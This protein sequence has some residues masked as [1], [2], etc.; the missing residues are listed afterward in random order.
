M[1]NWERERE[2]AASSSLTQKCLVT[3]RFES[4]FKT[5]ENGDERWHSNCN[6]YPRGE[7]ITHPRVKSTKKKSS[8]KIKSSPGSFEEKLVSKGPQSLH[9]SHQ[10]PI[11]DVNR[12]PSV[13]RTFLHSSKTSTKSLHNPFK[14]PLIEE[15][16]N[17]LDFYS[18]RNHTLLN[19]YGGNDLQHTS[20][21]LLNLPRLESIS[22]KKEKLQ[23]I[24]T[25]RISLLEPIA[26]FAS[27]VFSQS[28]WIEKS[29]L[30]QFC[31]VQAPVHWSENVYFI[32]EFG[33]PGF[34]YH[35]HSSTGVT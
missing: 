3:S 34:R 26:S 23:Q 27:L 7:N 30:V 2:I 5:T 29:H 6:H 19:G 15:I 9:D 32:L 11:V 28:H 20:C 12:N 33:I 21:H 31:A 22:F 10:S 35:L 13:F 18:S 17:Y 14:W 25:A 8:S 16:V 1:A 24:S 4:D